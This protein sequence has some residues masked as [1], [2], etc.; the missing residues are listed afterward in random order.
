LPMRNCVEPANTVTTIATWINC[1]D[2]SMYSITYQSLLL[3]LSGHPHLL[4]YKALA[5]DNHSPKKTFE[6]VVVVSI[7]WEKKRIEL[8]VAYNLS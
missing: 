4:Q 6:L 5:F 1:S 8:E 7:V 2:S 3:E